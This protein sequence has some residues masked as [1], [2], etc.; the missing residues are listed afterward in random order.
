[1][2][3]AVHPLRAP[4]QIAAPEGWGAVMSDKQHAAGDVP[5]TA[6]VP[7]PAEID[8]ANASRLAAEL[9]AAIKPGVTTL[10]IDMTRTTFCDS[11]GVKVIARARGRAVAEGVDLRLVT[12]SP[13]V[14]RILAVT[15]LDTAVRVCGR[16][17]DALSA[18]SK[19]AGEAGG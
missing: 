12:A 17:E 6:V 7:M 4:H 8:V 18:E 10:V 11:L 9:D 2:A 5:P 3:A 15:G 1:M 13:Q 14:L 16:L 19:P